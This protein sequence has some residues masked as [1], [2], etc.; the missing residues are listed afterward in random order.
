[1]YRIGIENLEAPAGSDHSASEHGTRWVTVEAT[2]QGGIRASHT[3]AEEPPAVGC[4][5]LSCF[6]Q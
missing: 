2:A 6:R 1:M 3:A 4:R 5:P